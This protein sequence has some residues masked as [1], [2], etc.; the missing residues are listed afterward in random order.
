[1]RSFL[2]LVLL[3][4]T[5]SNAAV[6]QLLELR[7]P[8]YANERAVIHVY[9]DLFSSRTRR[10]AA[11]DLGPEGSCKLQLEGIEGT[12]KVLISVADV[13][14]EIFVRPRQELVLELP[15]RPS[16]LA[17]SLAGTARVDPLFIGLDPMDV[18]ALVADLNTRLDAF[19]AEDLATDEVAGMQAVALRRQDEPGTNQSDT[20]QRPPTLFFTPSWSEQRVDSFG[21]RLKR[22]YEAV[23]DPWFQRNLEMGVGGLKLGPKANEMK[24]YRELMAGRRPSYDCPEYVRFFRSYFADHLRTHPFRTN[25]E[26]LLHTVSAGGPL[27]SLKNLFRGHDALRSDPQLQELVILD[28]LYQEYPG[29]LLDREGILALIRTISERS[30]FPEHRTIAANMLWDLT[31][32]RPGTELPELELRRVDGGPVDL[33]TLL[34]GISCLAITSTRCTYCEA[35]LNALSQL[36]QS[37]PGILHE[38]VVA[39]ESDV[40]EVQRWAAREKNTQRVW[41]VPKEPDVFLD[42]LRVRS[43]PTFFLLNDGVLARSPAPFPSNGMAA[44]LHKLKAQQE[45]TDRIKFGSD[46]ALPPRH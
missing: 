28:Q 37:Y 7:S 27:D 39:L 15:E 3:V 35:E 19:I 30:E 43:I 2:A 40:E 42:A 22:F 41:C 29:K 33:D 36:Q 13:G 14:A 9:E 45:E 12:R 34:T 5:G 17:R 20:L 6:A 1:M 23:D 26:Q 25:E 21:A 4:G 8:P 24:A 32:M 38:V 18:N 31:T 44:I 11:C 46:Q 16:G 10:L